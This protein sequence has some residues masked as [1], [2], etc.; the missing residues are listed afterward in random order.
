MV[1]CLWSLSQLSI[2]CFQDGAY[3]RKTKQNKSSLAMNRN[4]KQIPLFIA[5]VQ[6]RIKRGKV[7][8]STLLHMFLV[9]V[10]PLRR[11][12]LFSLWPHTHTNRS[13]IYLHQYKDTI[14]KRSFFCW[15][16]KTS[17]WYT[18]IS[19]L[20]KGGRYFSFDLLVLSAIKW[21]KQGYWSFFW[22]L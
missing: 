6:V 21:Y 16:A 22:L 15:K 5:D 2:I 18:G 8:R 12:S 10:G 1:R 14:L 13:N 7:K 17:H 9:V 20:G 4:D 19:L 11:E 3:M